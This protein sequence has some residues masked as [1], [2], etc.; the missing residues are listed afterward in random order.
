MSEHRFHVGQLVRLTQRFP[1]PAG[2]AVYEVVRLMP[3][4]E[5][6]EPHYRVKGPSG[7]ERAASESQL[8][9]VSSSG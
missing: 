1:N 6:G 5:N 4:T 9:S 2:T 3:A 7:P 8:S